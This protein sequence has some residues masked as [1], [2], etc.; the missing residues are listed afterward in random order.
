M[1]NNEVDFECIHGYSLE[2]LE[3]S[4]ILIKHESIHDLLQEQGVACDP[5]TG[6]IHFQKRQVEEALK[7]VPK[8]VTL[9]ARDPAHT[10]QL[11]AEERLHFMP[12]S[13][14]VAVIDVETQRR[15][16]STSLDVEDLVR[17][18]QQLP[19]VEVVRAMVTATDSP[20][21]Q[22]DLFEF[23]TGFRFSTKH[24]HHRTV[25][26]ANN[27]TVLSMVEILAGGKEAIKKN[28][29]ISVSYCPLSPLSF[30]PEVAQSMLEFASWGIPIQVL[31]M[32]MGG[33]TSPVTPLG[34]VI[35]VNA[36]VVAGITLIQTLYPEAPVLYG[37]VSS[38][39][40]MRTGILALGAP[41]RGLINSVLAR[42][43]NYYGIPCVTGGL[44]C[45]AKFIDFQA[46]FEKALTAIPLLDCANMISGMGLMNSADTY[47]VEQLVLDAEVVSALKCLGQKV[48]G[49]D[50]REECDL[51]KR[52]G[53]RKHYLTED[54]T[55]THFCRLWRPDFFNRTT[56]YEAHET[57]DDV[58]AR[59]RHRARGYLHQCKEKL[60]DEKTDQEL[61]SIFNR[62]LEN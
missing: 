34:E 2:I 23:L 13:T 36:E 46:G 38:V 16:P 20:P 1:L 19:E 43:A 29:I 7:L 28:P 50:S 27:K 31:S 33:A 25:R 54:H 47:S 6:L 52:L 58:H 45:D 39:L 12:S 8:K 11:T 57:S 9:G 42:M 44:S 53:P 4:G 15:R 3:E 10:M 5:D 41:E 51:I 61:E 26:P 35:L 56:S 30:C 14:G 21:L 37:S 59:V 24:F 55:L 49:S 62:S 48:M 32:A 40:D 22:A 17:V 18:Q 60:I